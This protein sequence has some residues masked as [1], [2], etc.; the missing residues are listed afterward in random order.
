M[1]TEYNIFNILLI[2]TYIH[3]HI[4]WR[5]IFKWCFKL[6]S[7]FPCIRGR[8]CPSATNSWTDKRVQLPRQ[9]HGCS[10]WGLW[11]TSHLRRRCRDSCAGSI[12]AYDQVDSGRC[13]GW[14]H[15]STAMKHV[16][17]LLLESRDELSRLRRGI[18]RVEVPPFG[19]HFRP[20]AL[21]PAG[22]PR[23]T[24]S[25]HACDT[26]FFGTK[27]QT[28]NFIHYFRGEHYIDQSWWSSFPFA[29]FLNEFVVS[30]L[31][32]EWAMV[33]QSSCLP[34]TLTRPETIQ[35]SAACG[36]VPHH[37][38]RDFKHF[39]HFASSRSKSQLKLLF[40]DGLKPPKTHSGDCMTFFRA[41][42][43]HMYFKRT[44]S[45]P[46]W[47]DWLAGW[48]PPCLYLGWWSPINYYECVWNQGIPSKWPYENYRTMSKSTGFG[49]LNFR[50]KHDF[51]S[52][53][54]C[55]WSR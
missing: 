14:P 45:S 22:I 51:P 39:K 53:W 32:G 10:T 11:R 55:E 35:L 8:C 5:R 37:L 18:C 3:R 23:T 9:L 24:Q 41:L 48:I 33:L 54:V 47:A 12:W 34:S 29:A 50:T 20:F 49:V 19:R 15:V 1:T 28:L 31:A 26:I 42:L 17:S 52:L 43:A 25:R 27:R 4:L 6:S 16:G 36:H 2:W 40:W 30:G 21:E 44:H 46:C 7:S 38:A 13:P